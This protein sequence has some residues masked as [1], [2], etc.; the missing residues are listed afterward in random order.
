MGAQFSSIH[1]A[2]QHWLHAWCCSHFTDAG[3]Y[4]FSS[5]T[6]GDTADPFS[7]SSMASLLQSLATALRMAGNLEEEMEKTSQISRCEFLQ[8]CSLLGNN[9][10]DAPFIIAWPAHPRVLLESPN[11]T[12]Q[13]FFLSFFMRRLINLDFFFLS[14]PWRWLFLFLPNSRSHYMSKIWPRNR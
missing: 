9:C 5:P 11:S 10:A 12:W 1:L 3:I 7:S 4:I 8:I 13:Y 2:T 6:P 14:K